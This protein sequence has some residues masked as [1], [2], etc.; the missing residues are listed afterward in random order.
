MPF[1]RKLRSLAYQRAKGDVDTLPFGTQ[2]DVYQEGYEWVNHS[3]HPITEPQ[4][5]R[6]TI[7]GPDCQQPYSA[8]LF[9]ISAMSLGL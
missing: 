2:R 8:S 1:N 6:V 5:L 7:G 3:L 4:N 9:N